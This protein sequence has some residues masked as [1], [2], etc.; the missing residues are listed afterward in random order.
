MEL[1]TF[2]SRSY[3]FHPSQKAQSPLKDPSWAPAALSYSPQCPRLPHLL[4]STQ[5]SDAH[6]APFSL[7]NTPV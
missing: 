1:V 2:R 4:V 5:A 7:T 6:S 3:R